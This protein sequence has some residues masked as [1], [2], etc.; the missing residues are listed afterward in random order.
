[1]KSY[2]F[3][4]Y[5]IL[6]EAFELPN[7]GTMRGVLASLQP[8]NIVEFALH[9]AQDVFHLNDDSTRTLAQNCIKAT[10]KWL[11][12][13]TKENGLI[14]RNAA[15]SGYQIGRE[16]QSVNYAAGENSDINA[17]ESGNANAVMAA[18]S[19]ASAAFHASNDKSIDASGR[20]SVDYLI[21]AASNAATDAERAWG[22]GAFDNRQQGKYLS[23]ANSY[24]TQP[25]KPQI[26]KQK[27][28]KLMDE[29]DFERNLP[30]LL[31]MLEEDGI[32][33][34]DNTL[35]QFGVKDFRN[36]TEIAKQIIDSN[37][38]TGFYKTMRNV[39]NKLNN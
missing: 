37:T 38:L 6:K 4:D 25:I 8:H 16:A 22:S 24:H 11:A 10:Q 39:L 30:I 36:N 13:P 17:R 20:S 19:A 1:M 5:V 3:K 27:I 21:G 15:Q 26:N 28:E 35:K 31:D 34:S 14:A 33:P 2:K 7:T 29:K 18:A 12:D 9:C 32:K 23:W